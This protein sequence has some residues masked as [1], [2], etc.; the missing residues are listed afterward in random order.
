MK[1]Y[2]TT[3][4]DSYTSLLYKHMPFIL[5]P[6]LAR[7]FSNFINEDNDLSIERFHKDGIK[8]NNNSPEC[9]DEVFWLKSFDYKKKK[10][11]P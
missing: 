6:F 3:V 11:P 7:I 5:N 2:T 10:L 1:K 4:I 9:L 8:I